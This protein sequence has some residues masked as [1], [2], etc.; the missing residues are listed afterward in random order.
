M[1]TSYTFLYLGYPFLQESFVQAVSDEKFKYEH[2][3]RDRKR[4]VLRTPMPANEVDWWRKRSDRFEYMASKRFACIIGHVDV[5]VHVRLLKGMRRM[6]DGALLKDYDHPNQATILPLQ[7]SV[8]KVENE[9]RRYIEQPSRPVEEDFPTKSDVFFLGAKFY[10]T[11][12]TV[13]G[14]AEDTVALKILVPNDEHYLTEPTF[15]RDIISEHKTRWIPAYVVAKKIGISSLALSKITSSL[16]V[17][18]SP[19]KANLGLNLKFEA[20]QQKVV[21]YTRKTNNVWEYSSKAIDLLT[22]YKKQFP[23]FFRQLDKQAQ[24]G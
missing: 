15:G 18:L 10:G 11:L 19:D 13:I 12:A 7:T 23:D 3:M 6:D 5:C 8:L 21:G 16:S 4:L 17:Q 9:D 22:E 20:K 2:T 14:H 1:L 24:Q